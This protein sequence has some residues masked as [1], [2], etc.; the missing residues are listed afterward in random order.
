M[1]AAL[2]V[3]LLI[4]PVLAAARPR[5]PP[6]RTRP[7]WRTCASGERRGRCPV[8]LSR[9]CAAPTRRGRRACWT[10][11]GERWC[12]SGS[13][14][15][16]SASRSPTP[17]ERAA[18]SVSR[19]SSP[20]RAPS[21]TPSPTA[22]NGG[23]PFSVPAARSVGLDVAGS[24]GHV[25]IDGST[26]LVPLAD[27]V[28]VPG[29]AMVFS[30]G[31]VAALGRPRRGPRPGGRPAHHTPRRSR[32]GAPPP[33]PGPGRGFHR[34]EEHTV[35]T[36]LRHRALRHPV[37][38]RRHRRRGV[39]VRGPVPQDQ[40]GPVRWCGGA[41]PHHRTGCSD[42]PQHLAGEPHRPLAQP[43]DAAQDEPGGVL[44]GLDD[45]GLATHVVRALEGRC[46]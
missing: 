4:V 22:L 43:L 25:P 40:L 12:R 34:H 19:S 13:R 29:V 36:T 6:Q 21:R 8:R 3:L 28:P 39:R 35:K 15:A 27:L 10:P 1:E 14:C 38:H 32:R 7:P 46:R 26:L 24:P 23:M 42:L 44:P 45:R 11:R 33:C 2:I 5:A 17:G 20:R 30:V 37:E 31:D 16:R 41:S 9:R 18:R